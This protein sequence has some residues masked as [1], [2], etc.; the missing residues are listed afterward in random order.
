MLTGARNALQCAEDLALKSY[1][2]AR[3]ASH[4]L[5][6]EH[7]QPLCIASLEQK[8][9]S[10]EEEKTSLEAELSATCASAEIELQAARLEAETAKAEAAELHWSLES[11]AKELK[12]AE[13]SE[14]ASK[15]AVNAYREVVRA[16]AEPLQRDIA[17]FLETMGLST[18]DLSPIANSISISELFRWLR[19]C[20]S[21]ATSGNRAMGDLSAAVAV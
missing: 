21:M 20:V 14:Q 13:C 12:D 17:A 11:K 8:A 2:A 5:D 1:V 4:L 3:C 7:D 6:A 15:Q 16:G 10:L 9:R 19:A 18:P